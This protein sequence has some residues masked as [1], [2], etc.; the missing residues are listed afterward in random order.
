[1]TG[2]LERT[3]DGYRYRGYEIWKPVR[4]NELWM[5][6]IANEVVELEDDLKS[7]MSWIDCNIEVR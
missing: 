4:E 6:L 7:C 3:P 5:I 2:K 1:M